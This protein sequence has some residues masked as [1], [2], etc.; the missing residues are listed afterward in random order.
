M[1]NPLQTLVKQAFPGTY[2]KLKQMLYRDKDG[3]M[4]RFLQDAPPDQKRERRAIANALIAM[5]WEVPSGHTPAEILEV[6]ATVLNLPPSVPGVVVEAGCFKGASAAKLSHACAMRGRKLVLFDSFEGIPPNEE[7]HDQNIF[8][9]SAAFAAGDYAGSLETVQQNIRRFG[10]IE[11]CEFHKGWFE[12]TMPDFHQ[13]VAVAYVDVDLASSTRTCMKHL[14]PLLSPGGVIYSQDGHLPLV[15]AVLKDEDFWVSEVGAA[16]PQF[17][18][19]GTDKLVAIR[20][21]L[22]Q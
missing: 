5:E 8:G 16:P 20:K 19:L 6:A 11:Q 2:L 13:P 22:A 14:Y 4:T 3:A 21:P 15:I 10:R 18:G 1:A 17:T 7:A 9:G 12:N